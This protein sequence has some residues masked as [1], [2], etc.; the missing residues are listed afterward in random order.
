MLACCKLETNQVQEKHKDII[1][2]REGFSFTVYIT[3]CKCCGTLIDSKTWI[4]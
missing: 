4:D 1:Q 3:Y 2:V